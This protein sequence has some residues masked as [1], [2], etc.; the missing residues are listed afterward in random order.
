MGS[1]LEGRIGEGKLGIGI[2][3]RKK[4]LQDAGG[5]NENLQVFEWLELSLRMKGVRGVKTPEM[6]VLHLEPESR[7]GLGGYLRRNIEY[8]FW[9]HSLY[10]L[11]P[12]KLSI[13]AFPVKLLFFIGMLAGA[14]LFHSY[15]F[16]AALVGVYFFWMI[17]HYRLLEKDNV[18]KNVTRNFR[19]VH[20]KVIAF[21]LAIFV[22]SAGEL[23]GDVGK[24]LGVVRNP[25]KKGASHA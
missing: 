11:H 22:L 21:A 25:M 12:K 24:L 18:V 23:A 2:A 4:A 8:G 13:F 6:T 5:F 16:V 9:Y 20:Q 15:F 10:Y 3:F 7:F 14:I 19:R 17:A 1:P